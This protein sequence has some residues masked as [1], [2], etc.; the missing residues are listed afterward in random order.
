MKNALLKRIA[1]VSAALVL[2]VS[3]SYY[4]AQSR[5]TPDT[6]RL[7]N[8]AFG[9]FI[10]SYTAGVI[11]S[12]SS[13]R[14]ILAQEVADSSDIG[15]ATSV[16]L[17]SFS[18]DVKGR[19]VWLDRRT[20]EF[21]P[22]QRFSSG[23]TFQAEFFLS[24]VMT[25]PSELAS[26][27][28]SFQIIP[29][30]FEVS[31]ENVLPYEKTQLKK[32]KI[33][34]I[35]TTADGAVSETVEKM[36]A[37]VQD[38]KAL[39]VTW[40]HTNEGKSHHFT[41]EEVSRKETASKVS[42]TVDGKTLGVDRTEHE[43]IEIPSLSDFKLMAARVVQSPTQHVVLQF[44]DPILEKQN[45]QG[46]ISLQGA[47]LDYTIQDNQILVYPAERLSGNKTIRIEAGIRNVLSYKMKN[48][49]SAD[50][51][52][53]QVSPAVRFT[54][55][56]SILPSSDGMVLPFEAVNLNA[57][58]ITVLKIFE[59]NIHQFLQVNNMNGDYQL[60]RVGKK[61]LKKKLALNTTGVTDFA[62]W[63]RYTLNLDQLIRTEPGAIYQIKIS[64]KKS[65]S[66]YTCADASPGKEG[67]EQFNEDQEFS[68]N[69]DYEDGYYEE[70]YYYDEDYDWRQRDNPCNS[71]YFNSGR[72][73]T[74][75]I[76]ASDLGLTAKRGDDG[77]TIVLVTDIKTT[78]P[79][80][81][82]QVELFDFQQQS[83]GSTAT[84]S[85]GKA[86]F[87]TKEA[88]FL[89]VAR[90]GSQRGYLKMADGESLSV[91]SFDVSGE[92]I[93]K[94]LKGFLYGD[95]GVWR[96]G[97]SLYLTFIL[98][99]RL[100]QLPPNHPVVFE[101]QN[102]Q[103]QVTNK[104][105]RS[106][107]ENGFYS[108]ATATAP[109][110]P[111]GNWTGRIKAGGL[112]YSQTLKIETIKPNRLK[113]NLDFGVEKFVRPEAA[114]KLNVKWLHGAPGRNL[115]AEFDMMLVTA[116]T[117]F[118]KFREYTF[119]DVSK[120]FVSEPKTVFEGN[121]DDEGNAVIT[122]DLS[123]GQ[124]A[125]GFLNAVFRGKVYEEGGNFSIDRISVPYY[126]YSSYTG[127]KT[128]EGE[129]YSGILYFDKPHKIDLVTLDPEGNAVSRNNIEI[130]VFK[131][132][133]RWWWDNSGQGIANYVNGSY[134]RIV[135]KATVNTA[136]GKGT[137]T[138]EM[139]ASESEYGRYYIRACDPVSGH[140][141]GKII[142]I[143]E[144]GWYSR[145]RSGNN[146]APN[147]L[148]FSTD[149]ASYTIGDKVTVS[150][151]SA[152][153]GRALVSIESGT[154]VLQ[155]HWIQTREGET[156]F[157]FDATGEM[158]PNVYIHV[159]MLQAHA[160]TLNELPIRLYGVT[161]IR[162]EDPGTRLQPV[163]TM[164]DELQ[165]GQEVNI[166]VSEKSKRKM[167]YTIAVVD[168]GLLDITKFRTPDAWNRFY[169]REALG[170]RTWDVFDNVIGAFG[171]RLER[172]L[173][174]G[175]D[176]EAGGQDENP[177]A[178]RFKPV[179]K[180]F[181]PF[182]LDGGTA[183]HKFIMPEYIGSVKTMVVAGYDGSY[184]KAEKVTP[185]KK[186]L[187][188]LATLPRV[189][190]PEE[191]LRLPV[192][193]FSQDKNIRNAKVSV[194]VSGPLSI[195]GEASKNV[196][197]GGS[198]EVNLYFNLSVAAQAG[199]AKV[200]V[201]A[202]SG[203]VTARDVIEIDVRNPNI[204]VS[205]ITESMVD[206]GKTWQAEVNPFGIAGTNS[207]F[208]EISNLPPVNLGSRMRYLIQYPYGCVEQTT[209]SVFPQL[210][211]SQIKALNESE[212]ISIQRN[213]TAGIERLKS[214]V[215]RDGGFGYWPGADGSDA[216]STSYAG[217]FLVEAAAKGYF[218][219]DDMIKRWKKFQKGRAE[220]W[221]R[222]TRYHNN[223]L[224]QAYRLY[225]LAVAGSPEIGAMNRLREDPQLSS[226]AAW[227][228]VAGY[229]R[230]SQP[231]AAKKIMA[232]LTTQVKPYRELG[233]SYGSD[234][235]DR[236]LILETLVL[237]N[238]KTKA[239]ELLKDISQTLSDG[240][241][242]MSTQE[243][244][245]SLRAVAS[246]AAME[247]RGE[248]KFAYTVNGKTNRVVSDLPVSQIQIPVA[249]MKKQNISVLNE[250]GGL[251]FSR[252]VMEGT[253]AR[254]NEE[255][256]QNNLSLNVRYTDSKGRAIDVTRLEQGTQFIA[257]VSVAHAGTR[258]S[259]ENIALSQVFPSGWEIN[260]LRLND[261]N[262][263]LKSDTYDYQDIRD[264]RVYT[265]FSLPY[266]GSKRFKVMLT[267]SY[268][269][270]YYLP[271]VNCEAMYDKSIYARKKGY[272][273]EV[274]NRE[275]Q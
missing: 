195:N 38:G 111:T 267:A 106:S 35:I 44:S 200:E 138:L 130:N 132:N 199:I 72:I 81:N 70:D 66:T 107:S 133:W 48:S 151:P 230:A 19:T 37:P 182:T 275:T 197:V 244:A 40:A 180:F 150:I 74:K 167:T 166:S 126:P 136:N 268:A 102:P 140:C 274:V 15:K 9:E 146:A 62:R 235:R 203:N 69:S 228:L 84:A 226:T 149:K 221:R 42:V 121:T 112:N 196:S 134:S 257:E 49:T 216:W 161:G 190:G 122:A 262:Q 129:K 93:Q 29:Q 117:T 269:G 30:N 59:N 213:V 175:G 174:V 24:K 168:E 89:L 80:A 189:L 210:Y 164:A 25:V 61:V 50:V 145:M 204:P 265:Y 207:A 3:V 92:A 17:F 249:D 58:D 153:Q 56:G 248:L 142:Y 118:A 124:Q 202:S 34:G 270:T 20:V 237:L 272:L 211:L 232:N 218:V 201:I 263:F 215:Q 21:Q 71:S 90:S 135:K 104:I 26:F 103:G 212:K 110:A 16:K 8:P 266:N 238:E 186:P 18:P 45:L 76:L 160:Q 264:D 91:S 125:P 273:V 1:V 31:I 159:S 23:G 260:N 148:S 51:T 65:Y 255:D 28:Y 13:L 193:V 11:S 198:G 119:E 155:T 219:P 77:N 187:M 157:T 206:A 192:T 259:I 253:P 246:F 170:V 179:V 220:E 120:S 261:D 86:V 247:K 236:A 109:D 73:I 5:S 82:V 240:G 222:D 191:T 271:A 60:Y 208:I 139:K 7:V 85:D 105:V 12:S 169:S 242:W 243:T 181:G 154:R 194:K 258:S 32:Q 53:E 39:A 256:G 27:N 254:G 205:R 97:D 176:D 131:L 245:M 22:E 252:V 101:L 87:K 108:L 156:N 96:P 63:N 14:V 225:T 116:P 79:L 46:L 4:F 55:R 88:P 114:G 128:P 127:I 173:T 99:D 68:F 172:V 144:P 143:D 184:G 10:S 183:T 241:Y 100:R 113:I 217:H 171:T 177:R 231:E 147:I 123:E 152:G 223:D 94:G 178:N 137:Y 95:R 250:G 52:F 67:E 64:F 185:V 188:V 2:V 229:A 251:L 33:E 234:H 47:R 141:T 158:A 57:V 98:E 115:R 75:N 41:I 83:L 78:E 239:F 162:V 36:L 163:I 214:F 233:Y 227:M 165:P 43:E 224:Q 6:P 54:G 209:S